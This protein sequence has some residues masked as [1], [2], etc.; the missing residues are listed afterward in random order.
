MVCVA[1]FII[2]CFISVF[3]AFLSI[4]RRDIGRRYW[5]VFKKAWECVSKKV[6]LQK[7]ETGFKDDIKNSILRKVIIKKPHLVQP[8]SVA[9]EIAA[10][11]IVVISVWS[12]IEAT[13]AG[14]ALWTLGTC[15]VKHA[16]ACTLGAEV[17]S[18]DDNS[19]PTNPVEYVGQWLSDWGE[20]FGAVPDK[21]RSWDP[22][23]FDL[24]GVDTSY[25]NGDDTRKKA[26]DI[27]DPGCTVCLQSYVNQKNSKFFEEYDVKLIPFP[28]QDNQ[29]KFKYKNSKL[30][31]EYIFAVNLQGAPKAAASDSPKNFALKI[32]DRIFT[33]QD[34]QHRSYQ[35]LFNDYYSAEDALV[36]LKTWLSEFG[37]SAAEITAI[38]ESARSSVVADI[39][40]KNNDIVVDTIHAK[41]IP[42]MIYDERKHTGLFSTP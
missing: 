33:E 29:G 3:I 14:L 31:V 38:D 16:S 9:I 1:A 11:L 12:L 8:I 19:E 36:T 27:L 35:S 25:F 28:I 30:I 17:C 32:I 10:V 2:L 18:I 34:P 22:A 7:C 13:K 26:I 39:I 24:T 15:N 42:T 20:I 6:R 5:K 37:Y 23:Q 21:F 4:F 41:G 40:K